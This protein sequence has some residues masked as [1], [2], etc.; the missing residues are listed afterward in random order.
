M[1]NNKEQ[2]A[3]GYDACGESALGKHLGRVG[4]EGCKKRKYCTQR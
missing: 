4:R 3:D 2:D 1:R